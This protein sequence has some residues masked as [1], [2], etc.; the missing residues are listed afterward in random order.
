MKRLKNWDNNTWLSSSKYIN[1]FNKFLVKKAEINKNT[2]IVDV[3]C[4]RANII[5][6]LNKS[7]KFRKK[8]LGIDIVKNKEVKKNIEFKKIDAIKFFKKTNEK[9][10]IILIK[11]TIHFFSNNK[12]KNLLELAKKKLNAKGK[13]IILSLQISNNEIPCFKSMKVRLNKSLK[14]DKI[15]LKII[16]NNLKNFKLS[17]FNFKVK[18]SL[19]EYIKMLKNRY[20]SCLLKMSKNSLEKGIKE[21]KFKYKKNIVFNDKLICITY[22]N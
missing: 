18:I 13:I 17:F 16:K 10:D 9:F 2:I 7:F 1:S 4:G 20:I 22:K 5:S 21:I 19:N 12:I 11:Q 8:P 15:L 14:K 6:K 3:G